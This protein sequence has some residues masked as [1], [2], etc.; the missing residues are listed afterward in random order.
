VRHDNVRRVPAE[1]FSAWYRTLWP[2]V[3]RAVTVT[4]GDHDLA[5]EAV[6]EAFARALARW[7][8]PTEFDSPVAW[9][10]RVAVNEV[11]SRWRRNRLERRVLARVAAE[12]QAS[13]LPV[14]PRDDALWAAVAALPDRTRQMVALRYVLDL[15]EADVTAALGV[16]RGTVA[17]TLSKARQQLA[18][19]LAGTRPDREES[20]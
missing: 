5:E 18:T 9:P 8:R 20:T 14:E 4:V 1:E 19:V 12:P 16:T 6:A 17:S 2:P 15:P 11:R 13:V 3:L 7:P 10:H